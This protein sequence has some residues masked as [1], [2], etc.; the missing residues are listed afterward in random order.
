MLKVTYIQYDGTARNVFVP[1]GPSVMRGAVDN[2]V[3]G[4]DADCGGGCARATCHVY[5]EPEWLGRTGLPPQG[6]QEAS[7]L[8]FAAMSQPGSRLAR[9]IAM[10]PEPDGLVVRMPEGQH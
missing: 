6:S 7:M 2:A 10:R 5:V 8:G 9:Q 4:V 3:P 1:A